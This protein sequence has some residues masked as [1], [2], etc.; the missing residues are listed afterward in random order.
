MFRVDIEQP[1]ALQFAH[2]LT[3]C[4][5]KKNKIKIIQMFL[6]LRRTP[7]WPTVWRLWG[8]VG[9]SAV[10]PWSDCGPAWASWAGTPSVSWRWH[11]REAG[12]APAAAG[13]RRPAERRRWK[14][15]RHYDLFCCFVL[16]F[17]YFFYKRVSVWT[18]MMTGCSKLYMELDFLWR[19]FLNS[20]RKPE[21]SAL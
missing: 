9:T 12:S 14:N 8:I 13:A 5:Q 20:T 11:C 1:Q 21:Q 18:F 4:W 7:T 16:F 17:S 2:P 6:S 3:V 15:K 10:P 19:N